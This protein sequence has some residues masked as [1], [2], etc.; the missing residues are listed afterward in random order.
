MSYITYL[1]SGDTFNSDTIDIIFK[2]IE[3]NTAG[4]FYIWHFYDGDTKKQSD[5]SEEK[6]CGKVY[7]R[8]F[9]NRYNIRWSSGRASYTCEDYGFVHICRIILSYLQTIDAIERMYTFEESIANLIP[10]ST[11]LTHQNNFEFIYNAAVEGLVL[12]NYEIIKQCKDNNIPPQYI[13]QELN[14][15]IVKLYWFF[16]LTINNRPQ[17]SELNWTR[18]KDFYDT[19]YSKY[20]LTA[21]KTLAEPYYKYNTH[22]IM[23]AMR[24]WKMPVRININKF[25]DDLKQYEQLPGRY[26]F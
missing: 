3:D 16:L 2:E 7:K 5:I 20:E 4:Y 8:E 9:I 24:R 26:K 21:S 11:S 22:L 18:I 1:D 15:M 14:Y 23:P 17:F 13:I 10:D 12:N 19:C 25:L 6:P